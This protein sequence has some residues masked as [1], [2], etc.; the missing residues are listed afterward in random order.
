MTTEI[1]TVDRGPEEQQVL[2]TRDEENQTLTPAERQEQ[3]IETGE[4]NSPTVSE[5]TYQ[6]QQI[7][8]TEPDV[9]V[10]DMDGWKNRAGIPLSGEDVQQFIARTQTYEFERSMTISHDNELGEQAAGEATRD[11]IG[12]YFE[13]APT[14][15]YIYSV[16]QGEGQ[17]QVNVAM[18]GERDQMWMDRQQLEEFHD[19][20]EAYYDQ[21]EEIDQDLQYDLDRERI[22]QMD[23]WRQQVDHEYDIGVGHTTEPEQGMGR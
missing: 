8:V 1:T 18:T 21:A 17:T 9:G 7:G 2:T 22:E 3:A 4:V 20:T 6:S 5:Q 13:D 15:D 10:T 16:E 23:Q 11:A 19:L 14:R 12:E